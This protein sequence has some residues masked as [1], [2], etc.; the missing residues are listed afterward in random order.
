MHGRDCDFRLSATRIMIWNI[1]WV[2]TS[3]LIWLFSCV[4]LHPEATL[5]EQAVAHQKPKVAFAD[6]DRRGRDHATNYRQSMVR[7]SID[8]RCWVLS[9][10]KDQSL[11]IFGRFHLAAWISFVR[12]NWVQYE[13]NHPFLF[14]QAGKDN[15]YQSTRDLLP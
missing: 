6:L 3:A 14:L 10:S 2:E 7:R 11:T 1:E 12:K 5:H 13:S 4:S 9:P 8:G 15:Q